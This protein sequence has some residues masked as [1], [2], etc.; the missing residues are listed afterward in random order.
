[1]NIS[2]IRKYVTSSTGL[3]MNLSFNFIQSPD[4][5]NPGF[6]TAGA[7]V[8]NTNVCYL[9]IAAALAGKDAF[10]PWEFADPSAPIRSMLPVYVARPC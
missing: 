4:E 5:Y 10:I 2:K 3:R 6:R 7:M 8:H 9:Q 1:M